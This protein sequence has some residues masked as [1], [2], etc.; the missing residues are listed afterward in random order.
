M[1]SLEFATDF[2]G[3]RA[4]SPRSW[5]ATRPPAALQ[6]VNASFGKDISFAVLSPGTGSGCFTIQAMSPHKALSLIKT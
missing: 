1:L 2:S 6:N 5:P 3:R 4:L